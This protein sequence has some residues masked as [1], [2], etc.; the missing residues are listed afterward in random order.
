MMFL[1]KKNLK[2]LYFLSKNF[3]FFIILLYNIIV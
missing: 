1:N 3:V 2:K